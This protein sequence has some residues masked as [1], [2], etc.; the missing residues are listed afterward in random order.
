[1][2]SPPVFAALVT[3]ARE[4]NLPIAAHVPL[5]MLAS[6]AGP[7]VDSME[8]LRNIEMDCASN[9]DALLGERRSLL[10]AEAQNGYALRGQLHGK[11]RDSAIADEDPERCAQVI[12]ALGNTIQVPTARLNAMTQYPPFRSPD[13]SQ[14]LDDLPPELAADWRRAPDLMG[15]DGFIV[16]SNWTLSMIPRLRDAGVPI[17]AGTDTPIGWA[18]PG[19]SLHSELEILVKA[20]L[21]PQQALHSATRVPARFF[22]LESEMGLI[23]TGYVADLVILD[24]NPL[25]S[26][27][28]T[29]RI[30]TVIANGRIVR[31][32]DGT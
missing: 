4:A 32:P 19:Y 28:N 26:I 9:A 3:A 29:R 8:H 7:Y 15:G 12:R 20:G 2:V 17:G 25:R 11:Q 31:G 5:S 1:M 10:L 27:S 24:G 30:H 21:T 16:L 22:D 23:R 14:A 6:E 18:I 13:W